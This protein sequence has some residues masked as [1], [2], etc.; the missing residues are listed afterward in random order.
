MNN[1][2]NFFAELLHMILGIFII[3][4]I[5]GAA[6]IVFVEPFL[7]STLIRSK[8]RVIFDL[9]KSEIN[10]MQQEYYNQNCK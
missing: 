2:K 1:I 10:E 9:P 5:I 6:W 3:L 7:P 8:C 4:V